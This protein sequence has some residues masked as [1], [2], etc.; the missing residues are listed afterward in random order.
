[1]REIADATE[2][3]AVAGVSAEALDREAFTPARAREL[4]AA[5]E[6]RLA[7]FLD[8]G[9]RALLGVPKRASAVIETVERLERLQR[10]VRSLETG[11]ET[12]IEALAA[13][14]KD[15]L[16]ERVAKLG[17]F[18]KDDFGQSGND[19]LGA[20]RDEVA[21]AAAALHVLVTHLLALDVPLF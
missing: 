21:K 9:G 5:L 2:R 15:E 17:E 19:A 12:L 1:P 16:G 6:E 10:G 11:D 4:R 14:V 20:A 8:G 18:A 7:A 3:L 13:L